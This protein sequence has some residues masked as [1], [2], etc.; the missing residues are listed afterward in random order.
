MP[1]LAAFVGALI[2]AFAEFFA[3]WFTRQTAFLLAGVTWFLTAWTALLTF[4]TS[5]VIILSVVT[6][7]LITK[8]LAFLLPG[9]VSAVITAAVAIKTTIMGYRKLAYW[10]KNIFMRQ[11]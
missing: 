2:S 10:Y 4:V 3:R 11:L 9:N 6:P 1:L 5:T 8:A 7:P